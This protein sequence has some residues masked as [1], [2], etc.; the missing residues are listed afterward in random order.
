MTVCLVLIAALRWVEPASRAPLTF[1]HPLTFHFTVK[2]SGF[3]RAQ[4]RLLRGYIEFHLFGWRNQTNRDVSSA[5]RVVLEVN[6]ECPVPV[7]HDL[8][9]DEQIQTRRLHGALEIS[10]AKHFLSFYAFH[11]MTTSG[12]LCRGPDVRLGTLT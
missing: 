2:H 4:N 10:P 7:I 6:A 11:G 8:P 5:G 12:L 3:H 1:L 9:F